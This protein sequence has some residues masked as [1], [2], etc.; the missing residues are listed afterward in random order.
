MHETMMRGVERVIHDDGATLGHSGL[1]MDH[2]GYEGDQKRKARRNLPILRRALAEDPRKLWNLAHL[3][4]VYATLGRRREAIKAWQRGI[5]AVRRSGST[6]LLDSLPH[7][8]YA[9]W[10]VANGRPA[11]RVLR[12]GLARFPNQLELQWIRARWL[13]TKR[14]WVEAIPIL[15]TLLTHRGGRRLDRVLPYPAGIFGA[16]AL[17]ALGTCYFQLHQYQAAARCYARAHRA[18]P[19]KMEYRVKT[20][21]AR[22]TARRKTLAS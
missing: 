10:L 18:A 14:R 17:A 2:V 6:D 16:D 21:L 3:G 9:G 1:V 12:E 11:G 8:H 19:D 13:M 22:M 4:L 15:R 7:L 20:E 5:D